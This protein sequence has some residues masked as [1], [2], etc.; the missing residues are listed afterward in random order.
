M[1]VIGIIVSGEKN[2]KNKLIELMKDMDECERVDR[3]G[4][5]SFSIP[6]EDYPILADKIIELIKKETL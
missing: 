2:M 6:R 5:S 4:K 1:N 3:Q